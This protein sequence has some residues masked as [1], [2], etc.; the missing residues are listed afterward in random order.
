MNKINIDSLIS[1]ASKKLGISEQELR[2]VL[3]RGDTAALTARLSP[4]D[5]AKLSKLMKDPKAIDKLVGQ[6]G[7]A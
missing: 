2:K 7:K 3:S 5:K 6:N 4:Q 1:A